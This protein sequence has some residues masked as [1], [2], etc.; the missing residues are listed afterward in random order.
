[1]EGIVARQVKAEN[2]GTG[3][4]SG[5]RVV[6]LGLVLLAAVA[7]LR[8]SPMALAQDLLPIGQ[9]QGQGSASGYQDRLVSFRGIVTGMLEDENAAGTRFYTVFVQDVPGSEDGDPLTSDGLA[10]FAGARRPAL[11]IGD[12]AIISGYVTEFY[13]LTELDNNDL[14]IWVESRNNPLPEP[15]ILDPPTDNAQAAEYLERFE[16]MLV[17]LPLATAVGPA[18]VGCGFSMVRSDSGISRIL[19]RSG[20]E[21]VGQILGVLHPSDVWC[22]T[23]PAVATGDQITGLSG[24]LTYHFE[25]FK[26][27]YQDAAELSLEPAAR[28]WPDGPAAGEDGRLVIATF[29]VND[30]FDA[31]DD[32]GSEAEPK[33][34]PAEVALKQ[35]KLAA[36]ISEGLNC[37]DVL[38]LQEVENQI[39]LA[40]LA[41]VVADSCG[42]VYQVSEVDSPDGRGADVALVSNPERV[43]V[44][45]VEARQGCTGLETG[46][47]DPNSNCLL[48]QQPLHSRPPLQV[49]IVADG[50]PLI[51][52]VNHFKSKREGAEETAAWRLAQANHLQEIVQSLASA[53]DASPVIVMGDFNDYDGSAVWQALSGQG[54]LVDGLRGLPDD[55]RY[56][57]IFD[58]ASQLID[59]ILISPALADRVLAGGIWH[60]N[61]DYPLQLGRSAAEASL[62]LRSSD[63]DVPYIVITTGEAAPPEAQAPVTPTSQAEPDGRPDETVATGVGA[64]PGPP[65][66]QGSNQDGLPPTAA[67]PEVQQQVILPTAVTGDEGPEAQSGRPIMAIVLAT[68][69]LL[70]GGAVLAA[71]VIARRR[72]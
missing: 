14:A 53:D 19:A 52:L 50:Q 43:S 34:S 48:G 3:I 64:S 33:P 2:K 41:A 62:G 6:V 7:W 68:L 45:N 51:V 12:V 65:P 58:G 23:M 17:S 36:T 28:S 67:Q 44:V 38:G 26:I 10:I 16:G 13:G 60:G 9:I 31:N 32:T 49:E 70:G 56:S 29:N 21:A 39:L 37:P 4:A 27:V 59:W 24:P 30:Y 63:H 54:V 20:N 8:R 66:G 42:F 15:V 55:E 1:L 46:L 40:E 18:H 11:A 35:A 57:Y 22:D 25:R 61:A 69:L 72:G 47:V 71:A 5:W